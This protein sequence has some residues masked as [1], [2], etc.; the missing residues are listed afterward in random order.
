MT[1]DALPIHR[2]QPTLGILLINLGTPSAPEAGAIRRYLREFLSDRR[3]VDLP[4]A[5]WWPVLY[6]VILPFRP[7]RLVHA[8]GSIWTSAGSPLLATTRALGTAI[9]TRL[10]TQLGANVR[11]VVGMRY[12]APSITAALDELA[13]ANARRIVVLPLYPQ[14]ASSSTA[15]AF[16]AVWSALARRRWVPEVRTIGSYHDAPAYIRAL[17]DSVRAHWQTHGRGDHQ[18]LSFHGIPQSHVLAGDPYYCQCQKTARLLAQELQL[19][20]KDWT[21]AFQSRLGRIPWVRP[22]TDQVLLQLAS[23]GIRRLDVL[24]PGFAADCLETLEEVAIRYRALFATSGGDLRYI[25]ALNDADAHAD[26]L[27]QIVNDAAMNWLPTPVTQDEIAAR[28]SRVAA[29]RP[30]FERTR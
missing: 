9:E 23:R 2:A 3:V 4:A 11:V 14:Y 17:A 24:C 16:D 5:L 26:A 12:G 13:S 20:E 25:P 6:G 28:E 10:R 30:L 29:Q 15:T 8:Y 1:E 18:L 21:I 7:R 22:Y 19:G 27:A